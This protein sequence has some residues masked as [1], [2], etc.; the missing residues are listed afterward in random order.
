[1][2]RILSIPVVNNISGLG[3]LFLDKS[4]S[5]KIGRYLYKISQKKVHTVFFQNNDDMNLFL[6]RKLVKKDQSKLIPGSGV[7]LI[8]F[9]PYEKPQ[10]EVMK[11]A[12]IGR[13]L[14]DKGVF[15]YIQ[16]VKLVLKEYK[17]K[18]KFYILGELY[19]ENPTAVS[20]EQLDEWIDDKI[21]TYLEK[22]DVVEE[23]MKK[24]DCI[25][26]PS[27]REGLSKVLLESSAMEIPAITTD[28]P[29]CRDVIENSKNGFICKVKDA[30][31]LSNAIERF[32]FLSNEERHEMGKYGRKKVVEKFDENIVIDNYIKVINAI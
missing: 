13:L 26:L 1:M 23:E 22:T 27:Y 31:D 30:L 24:F 17:G 5:S 21:I 19:E 11:F 2:C 10:N 7:D 8:K 15:E 18:C 29:G 25:I 4:I 28:V 12:F 6:K 3:T 32:I 9:Q 20:K 14:R 16:A